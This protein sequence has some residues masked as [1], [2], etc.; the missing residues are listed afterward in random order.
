[1]S[2]W[3][4]V[5]DLEVDLSNED[6]DKVIAKLG[7][8]DWEEIKKDLKDLTESNKDLKKTVDVVLRVLDVAIEAF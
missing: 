2:K 3:D 7:P 1:M 6:L 8:E 5:K 4:I